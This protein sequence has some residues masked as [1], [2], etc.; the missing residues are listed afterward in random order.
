MNKLSAK[1]FQKLAGILCESKLLKEENPWEILTPEEKEEVRAGIRG[2]IDFYG[3]DSFEKLYNYFLDS[4]EMPY[5]VAKAR[6]GDPDYWILDQMGV[7]DEGES[8]GLTEQEESTGDTSELIR[9]ASAVANAWVKKN[10]E[11]IDKYIEADI[12]KYYEH[13]EHIDADEDGVH[14]IPPDFDRYDGVELFDYF[15][16]Q[17]LDDVTDNNIKE[18]LMAEIEASQSSP[19][20]EAMEKAFGDYSKT[21]VEDINTEVKE[22][23]EDAAEY[24][25]DP[26]AYYGL[27]RSD[28]Y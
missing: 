15:H 20:I 16:D 1:R 10:Q 24:A 8:Y 23:F 25:R 4:G 22:G 18:K 14:Y 21:V 28:F 17:I 7:V 9:I 19:V 26:Y 13:G 27:R 3:T 5:G 12:E 11:K 6:T 2:E